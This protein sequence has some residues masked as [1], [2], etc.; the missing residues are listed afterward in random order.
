MTERAVVN[1]ILQCGAETTPGTAVAANK[2][3]QNFNLTFTPKPE[4]KTYRGVGHRWVSTAEMNREWTEMAMDGP[5]DYQEFVYLINGVWGAITPATHSGGT[6]SKDWIV[7]P[8]V[9]GAIT[10]KTYTIQQ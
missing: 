1:Q 10:P 2:K 8:P 9:S 7:T 3:L 6:N 5:L 4:V